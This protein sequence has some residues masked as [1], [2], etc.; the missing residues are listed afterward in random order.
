MT[1]DPVSIV[2]ERARETF[3]EIKRLRKTMPQYTKVQRD[4]F[5]IK[6]KELEDKWWDEVKGYMRK[7]K[8]DP[9]FTKEK[10]IE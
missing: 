5:E 4:E 10:C 2:A 1:D 8:N 3:L 9:P 6:K 7:G